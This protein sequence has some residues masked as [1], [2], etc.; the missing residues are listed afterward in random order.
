MRVVQ[1]NSGIIGSTGNIM[2]DIS[3]KL[4]DN[5]IEN[6]VCYP[7]SRD[8]LKKEISN[9]I[10]IGNRYSRNLHLLL[11]KV[12]GLNGCFSI[13]DTIIFI[14]KIRKLKPDIIQLHNLHNCYINLPILFK[15]LKKSNVKVV[16]TL[17]DCWAFT[18]HCP[19]FTLKKC[20]KWKRGCYSCPSYKEYPQSSIDL[21]SFMWKKKKEWFTGINDLKIIT[22]SQWL[23]NL[24]KESFLNQ[25]EVSV[26]YN[27]INLNVF[28]KSISDFRKKYCLEEKFIILGVSFS[29]GIRK[30]LDIFID[31]A[32]SL[33]KDKYKIVLIG[34]ND[35]VDKILPSS[36]IS[37]HTINNQEELAEI[38]STANVFVNPTREEVLGL[39]NIESNACGTPVIT[40]DTGGSPECIT[41]ESGE[42]VFSNT[43]EELMSKIQLLSS[44]KKDVSK[45]IESAKRF[46]KNK[47]YLEYLNLYKNIIKEKNNESI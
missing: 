6:Y 23:A 4:T 33:D 21:S 40:F 7:K 28:K 34:T 35:K 9:S 18:G 37:I 43:V 45:C 36:I 13:I 16:W 19:Y 30:G 29:W 24:V 5:N 15:Y 27:G 44:K 8:N 31:L 2:L 26:I 47:K 1:I 17:H 12:T 11:A 22:P 41:H 39:V 46:D 20:N 38:Y 25:Y 14:K 3:K 42:I 10:L 32:N